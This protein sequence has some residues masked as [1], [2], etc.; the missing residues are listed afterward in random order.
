MHIWKPSHQRRYTSLLAQN[1]GSKKVIYSSSA[2]HYMDYNVVVLDGM[3]DSQI[4]L[5]K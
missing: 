2:E 4:V 5:E 1:L 3:L